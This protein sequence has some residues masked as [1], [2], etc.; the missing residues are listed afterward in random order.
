MMNE[1]MFKNEY[2]AS[3][4]NVP[5][6]EEL[7]RMLI[8]MAKR[9][10]EGAEPQIST[11]TI[12]K[13]NHEKRNRVRRAI[14]RTAS[15]AACLTLCMTS[16]PKLM[17]ITDNSGDT[18]PYITATEAPEQNNTSADKQ[19]EIEENNI[20]KK[21]TEEKPSAVPSK[22]AKP[23]KEKNIKAVAG[24]TQQPAKTGTLAPAE[25][26]DHAPQNGSGDSAII[27]E[28]DM[29]DKVKADEPHPEELLTSRDEFNRRLTMLDKQL[30]K[31]DSWDSELSKNV[32]MDERFDGYY[33]D[34]SKGCEAYRESAAEYK[35]EYSDADS[36]EKLTAGIEEYDNSLSDG[37]ESFNACRESYRKG[38]NYI[39]MSGT[40]SENDEEVC[41]DAE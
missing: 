7:K 8:E 20:D 23:Q 1:E 16:L 32:G 41:A 34:F 5:V 12:N 25:E 30:G 37:S 22:T 13:E 2:R 27:Y 28:P 29:G 17:S 31:L 36:E 15:L 19:E 4:N 10:E 26:A 35:S 18:V 40:L 33:D 21:N 14:I 39:E 9:C 24:I 38:A 11:I 6:N 3:E